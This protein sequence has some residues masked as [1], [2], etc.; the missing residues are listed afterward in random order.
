M[1]LEI[2]DWAAPALLK[3]PQLQPVCEPLVASE[4]IERVDFLLDAARAVSGHHD[5]HPGK[6]H[7]QDCIEDDCLPRD[8]V[9]ST[10]VT[11]GSTSSRTRKARDID[12]RGP[13]VLEIECC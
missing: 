11:A 9:I 8:G 5:R 6:E 12:Y 4:R 3:T 2:G 1:A 10:I 13:S 7:D